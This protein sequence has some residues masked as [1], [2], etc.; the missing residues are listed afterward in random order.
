MGLKDEIG[1]CRLIAVQDPDYLKTGSPGSVVGLPSG[2][3][4]SPMAEG[5]GDEPHARSSVGDL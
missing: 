3:W 2:S 4:P 1:V 5:L